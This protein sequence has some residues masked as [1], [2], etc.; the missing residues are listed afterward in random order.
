MRRRD[1]LLLAA[2]LA[3]LAT[4]CSRLSFVKPNAQRKGMDRVAPEYSFKE[5]E[6]SKRRTE[7][8]RRVSVANQQLQAGN[9]DAAAAEARAALKADPSLPETHTTMAFIASRQGQAE[10]AGSHYAEAAKLG[11]S[12]ATYNNYGAWLCGNARAAE[13]L[14]WFDNAVTDPNYGDRAGAL[15]NAGT[16]AAIAGQHDRVERDL[17]AALQLD[18]ANAVALGAMAE[19]QFRQGSYFEARAFSERRLS[20]APATPAALE[21]ASRIEE[22]LGDSTAAARYVRRLRTEFPQAGNALPGESSTP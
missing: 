6:A 1:L 8:R 20:A 19:H 21:L 10:L 22:K 13:S 4:A 5:T 12:G 11:P 14:R 18:P 3:L 15:A 2:A 16:C 9:L 7:A 17:R